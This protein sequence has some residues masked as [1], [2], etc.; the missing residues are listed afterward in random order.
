VTSGTSIPDNVI[1]E[2]VLKLKDRKKRLNKK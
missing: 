2:V 1:D